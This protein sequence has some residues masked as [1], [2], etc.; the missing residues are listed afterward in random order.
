MGR[1][2]AERWLLDSLVLDRSGELTGERPLQVE[3][4]TLSGLV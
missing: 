3:H 2:V 1:G 4:E